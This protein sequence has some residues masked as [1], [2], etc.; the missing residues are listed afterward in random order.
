[1]VRRLANSTIEEE[2]PARRAYRNIRR[3]FF[4]NEIVPGQKISISD[5]AARF[6][7]SSTPVIQALGWLEIQGLVRRKPGR[8]YFTEPISMEEIEQIYQLRELIEPSLL[9]D[10]IKNVRD[11]QL[12]TLKDALNGHLEAVQKPFHNQRILT[13]MNFHLTLASFAQKDIHVNIL[14][15]LF[16]LLYLKYRS[17]VLFATPMSAAGAEHQMIY[18][19]VENRNIRS[20]QE[21]M[22]EHIVNLKIHVLNCA[23]EVL[24]E[25]GSASNG[26]RKKI[27]GVLEYFI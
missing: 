21:A 1:M 17:S 27:L 19:H 14:R 2:S 25:S 22:V 18:S 8:G 23:R 9:P 3:M 16:D 12:G 4:Y 7:V 24:S 6:G 20:A 15:Y 13:D 26:S 10:A 5:L 11:D